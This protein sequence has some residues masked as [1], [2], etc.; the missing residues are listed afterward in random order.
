M[1]SRKQLPRRWWVPAIVAAL[2][3]VLQLP[4]L[5]SHAIHATDP[6]NYNDDARPWIAPYHAYGAPDG[7]VNDYALQYHIDLTS[8]GFRC[9]YAWFAYIAGPLILSK[10]LPYILLVLTIVALGLAATRLAGWPAGLAAVALC[11][12]SEAYLDR[13]TGG[14]PRSF[15]FPLLAVAVALLVYGRIRWL[16]GLVCVGALF[17]PAPAMMIGITLAAVLLALPKRDRGDAAEWSWRRRLTFLTVV[18]GVSAVLILPTLLVTAKYGDRIKPTDVELYP[19]AG[20]GGRY[21][22][23]DRPPFKNFFVEAKGVIPLAVGGGGQAFVPPL[24]NAVDGESRW[25]ILGAMLILTAIGWARLLATESGARRLVVLGVSAFIAHGIARVAAPYFYLPSRY[26]VYPVTVLLTVM[27]ASGPKGLLMLAAVD[28]R[29]RLQPAVVGIF[30]IV[31]LVFLGARGSEWTGLTIR[32][33]EVPTLCKMVAKLP[34]NVMVA[35][36]P[37][38]MNDVTYLAR[39]QVFVS[40]ETHQAFHVDFTLKMRE[41]VQALM[42]AYYASSSE[43]ILRLRDEFGVTHMLVD[44]RDYGKEVPGYF[45]PFNEVIQQLVSKNRRNGYE[46]SRQFDRAAIDRSETFVLLDLNL[47]E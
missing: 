19:E 40:K 43:P 38:A 21:Q 37:A 29:K 2:I 15:A 8:I 26:V 13:M 31:V 32:R 3:L 23:E 12:G 45:E 42:E 9:M 46:L 30:N 39:R 10:A 25:L 14:L 16:G 27:I 7:Y 5:I 41:R 36:Q 22:A 11:L 18:A 44:T 6:L 24:R 20:E 1:G 28:G 34:P 35:G 17:Y 47:V 4:S 33:D